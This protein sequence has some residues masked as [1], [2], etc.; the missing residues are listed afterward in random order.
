MRTMRPA[1]LAMILASVPAGPAFAGAV[2]NPFLAPD[3]PAGLHHDAYAQQAAPAPG[4]R[5]AEGLA[6]EFLMTD[7]FGSPLVSPAYPDGRRVMW[8]SSQG[9]VYKIAAG[10]PQLR[11]ISKARKPVTFG[12]EAEEV[13]S[14]IGWVDWLLGG[15]FET[16]FAL[17]VGYS[18]DLQ[19]RFSPNGVYAVTSADNKLY[20]IQDDTKIIAY[21]DVRAGD[22]ESPITALG[23]FVLPE[24]QRSDPAERIYGLMMT[25]DGRI[26]FVTSHG[27]VGVVSPDMASA[28]YLRLPNGDQ[29]S[30]SIATCEKGGIYVVTDKKMYRVQWTGSALSLDPATGA[31][32]SDY[33][34]GGQQGDIRIG[35]GSGSTPTLMGGP[36]DEDR[37]VV[38]SDG[39]T[40]MNLV[41][42]WRDAVPDGGSRIAGQIPVTFGDPN[43]TAVQSEQ[44]VLVSGYGAL[45]VNN[46]L[47][48][49]PTAFPPV[50][51]FFSAKPD[52][53]PFGAER[54]TWDTAANRF[55]STWASRT[56]S[57]PNTIPHMSAGSG[58]VYGV[59]AREGAWTLEAV[60]WETGQE[61]FTLPLGTSVR[62]NSYYMPTTIF[63]DGS[64]VYG[65][66]FGVVRVRSR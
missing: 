39:A 24:A 21:G 7:S 43:A 51:V 64:I 57:F 62:W 34:T 14:T 10:E 44:S 28:V 63:P 6:A 46:T 11:I 36:D 58:A 29:V 32:T 13:E 48:R 45:V 59:G 25:Y 56:L 65:S 53:Q 41:A 8:L 66:A 47:Q 20:F 40:R 15:W 60:D 3:G 23:E 54:F 31:W 19:R 18:F 37:L 17:W 61:L 55:T 33:D 22:A 38:I 42:F 49:R 4:P 26:A 52:V 9:W 5:S 30:N 2:P 27:L 1:I 16:P 35:N 50:N 12:L